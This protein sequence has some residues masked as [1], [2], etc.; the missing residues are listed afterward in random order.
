MPRPEEKPPDAPK[1]VTAL[2]E[3]QDAARESLLAGLAPDAHDPAHVDHPRWLLAHLVSWHRREDKAQY[4]ERYRLNDLTD[5][6]LLDERQAFSGLEFVERVREVLHKVTQKPTGSVVDRAPRL[7][8][9]TLAALAGESM[10]ERATRLATTLDR[11]TL[12]VQGPPGS[13]KTYVGAR[14][15]RALVVCGKRVGVVAVSHKVVRNL[16][17]AVRVQADEAG[18]DVRLGHR[19]GADDGES[20]DARGVRAF[21]DNDSAHAAL[22]GG[23]IN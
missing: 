4:W 3:Q 9:V 7:H 20:D 10:V 2:E 22:V 15:I 21:D 18:E 11:T 1:K 8:A 17:D 5:E 16:L 23:E 14:M 13:G 6:E 12:A 19:G